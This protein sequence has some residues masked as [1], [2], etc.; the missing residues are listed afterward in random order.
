MLRA[1]K[2]ALLGMVTVLG[3]LLP[4]QG[5]LAGALPA[6]VAWKEVLLVCWLLLVGGRTLQAAWQGGW[7]V[8]PSWVWP[9]GMLCGWGVGALFWFDVYGVGYELL[10]LRYLLQATV[11]GGGVMLALHWWPEWVAALRTRW[12]KV[13][14]CSVSLSAVFGGMVLLGWVPDVVLGWWSETISS[15]VPGQKIP[16]YHAAVGCPRLQGGASGPVALA[17]LLLVGQW[18]VHSLGWR[19]WRW[20][21]GQGVLLGLIGLSLTR[22][23][24]GLSVVC[25]AGW[26]WQ[27][28]WVRGRTLWLGAVLGG[29]LGGAIVLGWAPL[30]EQVWRVGSAQH[31][32]APVAGVRL[33]VS[34]H[35]LTGQLARSGPAARA[36][37]LEKNDDDK[38]LVTE[39]VLVDVLVQ[40]GVV[41]LLLTLWWWWT[42]AGLT[43]SGWPRW[44]GV[45]VIVLLQTAT[46]FDMMP[47]GMALWTA[48][49]FGTNGGR[50][51]RGN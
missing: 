44:W 27:A 35:L 16:L 37:N 45:V 50:G 23:V 42:V 46:L 26:A 21:V 28:G 31:L 10:A 38:A 34:E 4:W 3:V 30:R 14:L 25:L 49:G 40:L 11:W 1:V 6:V 18:C 17:T 36:H 7:G 41:G 47:V 32:T 15:W 9:L 43:P 33:A 29:G 20:G 13:Y 5:V 39:N 12:A 48:V 24:L 19:G 8:M 51:G 2:T 22:S